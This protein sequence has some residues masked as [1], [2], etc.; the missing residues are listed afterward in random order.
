MAN[1]DLE[2]SEFW[3]RSCK[4]TKFLLNDA[5]NLA[6]ASFSYVTFNFRFLPAHKNL[7]IWRNQ[8]VGEMVEFLRM[9]SVSENNKT[10][11]TEERDF[12]D[13]YFMGCS[14]L[15]LQYHYTYLEN[16]ILFCICVMS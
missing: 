6:Q 13:N 1:L 7:I 16:I 10:R 4:N 11:R 12:I 9:A 3:K 5:F 8:K 15:Q 14:I 2:L